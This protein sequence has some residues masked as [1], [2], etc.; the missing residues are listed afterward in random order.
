MKM[1]DPVPQF[2]YIISQLASRHPSLSYIHLVEPRAVG[3]GTDVTPPPGESL[4][5][6]RKIWKETGRPFLSAGG[7][8]PEIALDHLSEKSAIADD[9]LKDNELVVFG[10]WFLSNVSHIPALEEIEVTME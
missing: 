2:S 9:N 6:A 1:A 4:D 10:R 8:T 3:G 7:Y 5:F